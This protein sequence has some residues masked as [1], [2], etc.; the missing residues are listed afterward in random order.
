MDSF[1]DD[2]F[3]GNGLPINK[4]ISDRE[5]DSFISDPFPPQFE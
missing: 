5:M 4:S 2:P 1:I 3:P